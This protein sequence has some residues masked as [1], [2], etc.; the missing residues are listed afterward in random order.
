ML[1][2]YGSIARDFLKEIYPEKYAKLNPNEIEESFSELNILLKEKLNFL[3]N[4]MLE[5]DPVKDPNNFWKSYQ[6]KEQ[7]R[8]SAEEILLNEL[9]FIITNLYA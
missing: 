9:K 8:R 6:H 7:I 1:G 4:Q 5:K 2:K 3:I